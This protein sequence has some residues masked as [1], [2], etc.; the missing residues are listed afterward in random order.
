M[1]R[2]HIAPPERAVPVRRAILK[3]KHGC[4]V[5]PR[6]SKFK[7]FRGWR[8][9]VRTAV[10][11]DSRSAPGVVAAAIVMAT[12]AACQRTPP[13]VPPVGFRSDV[14]PLIDRHCVSCHV[15]GKPGTEASGLVLDSYAALMKGTKFG[16][17]VIPGDPLSSTLIMLVEGRADPS[18][19]MPHGGTDKLSA[20]EIGTLRTWVQQGAKND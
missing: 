14:A 6:G 9:R 7:Q 2:C 11:V 16:P 15:P 20:A 8:L 12:L 19:T 1:L 3:Y 17:V 4:A 18:I 5:A 10:T 13:S